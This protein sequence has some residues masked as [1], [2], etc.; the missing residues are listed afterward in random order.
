MK[1]LSSISSC[2]Q[3]PPVLSFYPRPGA[4]SSSAGFSLVEIL[5]ALAIL[6]LMSG[7]AVVSYRVVRQNELKRVVTQLA[8]LFRI[9]HDKALVS[10]QYY[11][12][13]LDLDKQT[14]QVE[15]SPEPEE[16]LPADPAALPAAGTSEEE[17]VQPTFVP[18]DSL[19][20]P[21]FQAPKQVR[22][23]ELRI[24]NQTPL[25][26]G[27]GYI[28]FFPNGYVDAAWFCIVHANGDS[29]S[30]ELQPTSGKSQIRDGCP[31]PG[32]SKTIR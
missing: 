26:Q 8:G 17:V 16:A 5:I 11:R 32:S 3:K 21:R 12:V 13:R 1:P 23:Q 30:L 7:I 24:P 20:L 9:T 14:C 22:L 18:E 2:Y 15:H 10:G 28:H 31:L 29:F 25:L 6:G 4:H 27:Q 19:L